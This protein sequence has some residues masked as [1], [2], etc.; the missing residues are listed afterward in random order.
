MRWCPSSDANTHGT[1]HDKKHGG[2]L[3]K[4]HNEPASSHHGNTATTGVT[5][6]VP[7]GGVGS[8][9]THGTH[10]N[11]Q[12][13]QQGYPAGGSAVYGDGTSGYGTETDQHRLN[14]HNSSSGGSGGLFKKKDDLEESL[15]KER[16]AKA[17]LDAALAKHQA[18]QQD[19]SGRLQAQEE[20]ARLEFEAAEKRLREAQAVRQQHGF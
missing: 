11:Q 1:H 17:E 19:A 12:H 6:G 18:A 20:K 8:A 5:H 14:D 4:T 3:S 10:H 15:E 16:K 7:T 13:Q 2:L 9:A